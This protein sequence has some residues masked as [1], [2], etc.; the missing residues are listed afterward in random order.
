MAEYIEGSV[1]LSPSLD[2]TLFTPF[3][4]EA[5]VFR[6]PYGE[7]RTYLDIAQQIN[8]PHA[9]RAVGV[10]DEPDAAG[11]SVSPR[12]WHGRQTHATAAGRG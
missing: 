11:D 1:T 4:R 6:I 5:A 2:W 9:Y 10:N 8:R 3:Q 12:D 7:T